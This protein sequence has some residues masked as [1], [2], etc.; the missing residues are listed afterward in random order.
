M[1]SKH[2]TPL[3]NLAEPTDDDVSKASNKFTN[4]IYSHLAAASS[5]RNKN[6]VLSGLSISSVMAMLL[7]G[8]KGDTAKEI[9]DCLCFPKEEETLKV[10]FKNLLD[11]LHSNNGGTVKLQLANRIFVNSNLTILD[12]NSTILDSNSTIRDD[13]NKKLLDNFAAEAASLQ[14]GKVRLV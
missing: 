10:G 14:E 13:F 12:S 4:K 7:L 6:I 8:A 11:Q 3:N 5:F 1:G 2:S 9:Q